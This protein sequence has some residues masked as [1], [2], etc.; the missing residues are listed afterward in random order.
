ML[1]IFL[2]KDGEIVY[3]FKCDCFLRRVR[4]KK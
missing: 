4:N 3:Y 2:E 1:F